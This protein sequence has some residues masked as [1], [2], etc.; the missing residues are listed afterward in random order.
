MQKIF[1]FRTDIALQKL[2]NSTNDPSRLFTITIPPN[3]TIMPLIHV[4]GSGR[5]V[6]SNCDMPTEVPS[7]TE[8]S[9]AR[10][11]TTEPSTDRSPTTEPLGVTCPPPV[12]IQ[13]QLELK[14]REIIGVGIG[15]LLGGIIIGSLLTL[16][17]LCICRCV[18][19]RGSYG[20]NKGVKY[21]KHND[22]IDFAS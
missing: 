12:S 2:L 5:A 20:V 17:V 19:H 4:S 11:P 22:E 3:I 16:L 21:E 15:L 6:P 7:T 9:T 10:S 18:C 8:P 14:D 13:D 1:F